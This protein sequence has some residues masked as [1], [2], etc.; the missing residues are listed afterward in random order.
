MNL[1]DEL[2]AAGRAWAERPALIE[3][4][5]VVT[6]GA[7]WREVDALRAG[8]AALGVGGGQGVGVR[9]RN[10]RAF[11][12]AAL[13]AAGCGGVVMPLHPQLR[14]A[15]LSQALAAAPLAAV[16]DDGT[17]PW[18]L[19]GERGSLS[20]LDG[21]PLSLVRTGPAAPLVPWV[22][23]AAFLRFTSGTT[24]AA[25]GVLLT[26]R[27]V[28]ERAAAAN[29]GLGLGPDDTVLWVLPMA[30]H[31]F[32]S[33]VLYLHAG[34]A[35]VVC[36]DHLARGLLD[37]AERHAAT[38]LYA[39][40]LHVR[41]LTAEPT[42]R[43]LPASLRRVMSVSSVLAPQAARAFQERFGLPVCQGYGI[44][45]V[46]LPVMNLDEA[47]EHPEA[48]GRP[49]PGFEVELLDDDLRPVPPGATGQLAV[50]GPGLFAGYLAPP[51][52][53]DEVLRGGFFLTGDLAHRDE[54]GRLVLDG[55][56]KSLI[57]IAG[58]KVFP[59]E[60]AGVL[61][62]HPAVL[63]ARVAR[64]PH[65]QL[66]EV[67]HAEVELRP[68]ARAAPSELL[69]LCRRQLSGYKVPASLDV[70][71]EIATTPSGKVRTG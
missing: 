68:G 10:G 59:E 15:E 22:A 63:R 25:K 50:R 16:V 24:G 3:G 56:L 13:A 21:T 30:Y 2:A 69:A 57:N 35:V 42:G 45:E 5:V 7:L 71:D 11:V 43:R 52:P 4:D 58:H 29:R 6:Y 9:A 23:D 60:V 41:L 1:C 26:H 62:Q 64:R 36:A 44:I 54:G 67:V 61:E 49:L 51:T 53:R 70:V 8:L 17:S 12:I 47:A 37:D 46:G 66:G 34:A 19:P 38:F 31:F 14:P 55:R 32:V 18:P 27:G 33:I 39:A 65:P 40:P 48:L 20:L 28:A